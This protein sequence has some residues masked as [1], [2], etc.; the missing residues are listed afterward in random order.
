MLV[1]VITNQNKLHVLSDAWLLS[2][3]WHDTERGIILVFWASSR[4]GPIK[5]TINETQSV[6]FIKQDQ[7]TAKHIIRKPVDLQSMD[8]HPVD[9]LYFKKQSELK[10]F[11]SFAKENGVSVYE[12]DIKPTDRYLME[13][14]ITGGVQ[15]SGLQLNKGSYS[16]IVNPVI[17]PSEYRPELAY[18]SFDIE[19]NYLSNQILS[20]AGIYYNGCEYTEQVFIVSNDTIGIESKFRLKQYNNE[21]DLLQGFF[22]WLNT[23]DPDVLIGWNVINFDLTLL[24]DRCIVHGIEFTIGRGNQKCRILKPGNR[25][26]NSIA[27]IPG[28]VVLDGI[29][30]LKAAFWKFESF[31]LEN[32]AREMLGKGKLINPTENRAEE[33]LALY[34]TNKKQLLKYNIEDCRLVKEIFDKA[35]LV[36]FSL[37]RA[38]TTGL[39]FGRNGGSVAAYDF[40]YLPKMHR[41]GYVAPDADPDRKD[42]LSSPG[43]YVMD[44]LPGLYDNVLVLDF[45]SLYPSIICTFQIDP[46]GMSVTGED[47]I[48]GF[49]G[50]RFNRTVSVLPSLI[51]SLWRQRDLAKNSKNSPMSHALKI[52]MNSFYGVLGTSACRFCDSRLTSSI[53]KRGHQILQQ[54]KSL[55]EEQGYSVI[56][57]DTDSV[58]VWLEGD[59]GKKQANHI[60][61]QLVEKLNNWWNLE[62]QSKHRLNSFLELEFETHFVK[63][64][65]PTVRGSSAGSKKRYAGS[66]VNSHGVNT[67]IF[68]GLESVRSDWTPLAREFQQEL[69]Q[70]V[71]DSKP[72]EETIR[73]T[74]KKLHR[75]QFDEKL[76]YRKRIRQALDK[77]KKNVPPHIQAARL[78][79][80]VGN[81]IEYVITIDGPQP[82]SKVDFPL[83]YN[84][85]QEKQLK[86]VADTIL[87]FVGYNFDDI[88]SGQ[89]EFFSM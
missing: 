70:L 82:R 19:S 24:Q 16:E 51:S 62:I 78:L 75:G 52:I 36:N 76:F 9:A 49:E 86:P 17:K 7:T 12:S 87:H 77:Y 29:D 40:L 45:K 46:L 15:F 4:D 53:T 88:I 39:V 28:R 37:E 8:K 79:P 55:I 1:E 30:T 47:A 59:I 20:I 43:G 58:F 34:K 73:N 6:C 22:S 23:V 56:Y 81:Q 68:K 13:R 27:I 11:A 26:Q 71:F 32:V 14:F 65:M 85:Y 31:S 80:E 33:V 41:L 54:T 74:V 10:N 63:F 61:K 60:G 25:Q 42:G 66:I 5:L 89:M 69:F 44:S 48:E 50:A 67:L 18:I 35:D 64:L 38:A 3:E 21:V 57:G 72:F 83:D 84:H 2:H